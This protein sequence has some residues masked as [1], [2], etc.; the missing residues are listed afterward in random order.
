MCVHSFCRHGVDEQCR[1]RR[2]RSKHWLHA[3]DGITGGFKVTRE[4]SAQNLNQ[5]APVHLH[6]CR[7]LFFNRS[8]IKWK[9]EISFTEASDIL[10]RKMYPFKTVRKSCFISCYGHNPTVTQ[11]SQFRRFSISTS[12]RRTCKQ[13]SRGSRSTP[14]CCGARSM[15]RA[16]EVRRGRFEKPCSR[17]RALQI[18]YRSISSTVGL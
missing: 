4:V 3:A 10:E 1:R 9:K 7:G 12:L 13:R 16:A 5:T 2:H 11:Y 17:L 15:I 18:F 6:E 8:E 14:S